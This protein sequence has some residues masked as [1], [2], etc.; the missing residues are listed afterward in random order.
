[1]KEAAFLQEKKMSL[2]LQLWV[3]SEDEEWLAQPCD[4][5]DD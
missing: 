1:M 3:S 4:G 5:K 2:K